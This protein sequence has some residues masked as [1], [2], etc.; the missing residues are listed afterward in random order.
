MSCV[1]A[2]SC[3]AVGT[4]VRAHKTQEALLAER[5]N[6]S[7]EWGIP[8]TPSPGPVGNQFFDVSCATT[9]NRMAVGTYDTTTTGEALSE[10]LA[11]TS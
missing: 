9:T 6:G 7:G 3:T 5:W 10:V 4:E 8:H 1:S 11:P 2:V